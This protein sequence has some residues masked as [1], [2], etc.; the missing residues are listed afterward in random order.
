MRLTNSTE[1][2][3]DQ[4]LVFQMWCENNVLTWDSNFDNMAML[5]D[6]D[7]FQSLL[8]NSELNS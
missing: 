4:K 3:H 2:K 1:Y 5:F 6:F 7:E 8:F